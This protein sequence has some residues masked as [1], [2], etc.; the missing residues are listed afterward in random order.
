MMHS[1]DFGNYVQVAILEFV[2]LTVPLSILAAH[3]AS[4]TTSHNSSA[5]C[6][7][8][9]IFSSF[10]DPTSRPTCARSAN[11]KVSIETPPNA[12]LKA[13]IAH[14]IICAF[15]SLSAYPRAV[16]KSY[17]GMH[18]PRRLINATM[19]AGWER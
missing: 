9:Y 8:V 13:P 14:M 12:Q 2:V 5:S 19:V 11:P 10:W 18:A 17:T 4:H 6:E 3:R 15:R 1:S 16:W 7:T